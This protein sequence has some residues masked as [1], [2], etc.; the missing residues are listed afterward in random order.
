MK[1]YLV[2]LAPIAATAVM[3]IAPSS[4]LAVSGWGGWTDH[5]WAAGAVI[6]AAAMTTA[7]VMGSYYYSLPPACSPYAWGAAGPC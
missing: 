4:A 5:P 2:A 6:A 1:K 7:A 3:A